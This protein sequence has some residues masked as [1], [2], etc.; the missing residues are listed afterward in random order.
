MSLIWWEFICFLSIRVPQHWGRTFPWFQRNPSLLADILSWMPEKVGSSVGSKSPKFASSHMSQ[1]SASKKS[2]GFSHL[3]SDSLL[4][5]T[6]ASKYGKAALKGI[7]LGLQILWQC[8]SKWVSH[9]GLSLLSSLLMGSWMKE[10]RASTTSW[11]HV[12]NKA[13]SLCGSVPLV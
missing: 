8:I 11:L 1:V 7:A 6:Y 13:Q 9:A 2:K 10:L 5:L 3:F 12:P 4:S